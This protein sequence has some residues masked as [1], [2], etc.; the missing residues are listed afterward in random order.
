MDS[1]TSLHFSYDNP[2]MNIKRLLFFTCILG[3]LVLLLLNYS[4]IQYS[5][6]M[7]AGQ[8]NIVWNSKPIDEVLQDVSVP[9]SVKQKL[10]LVLSIKKFATD[11]LGMK[12]SENYST[13]FDQQGK[14]VLWVV[15][16]SE[17]F[18]LKE[19]EWDFPF[20]GKV[21]Y[22][23][24][25]DRQLAENEK[26]K[27][28]KEG[29][30]VELGTTS[31]WSTLGWLK[32]PIMSEML[33]RSEGALA[34]LIIHE[35]THENIFITDK[36]TYNENL[37][38]FVGEQGAVFFLESKYGKE[39]MPV[40]QYKAKLGDTELFQQHILTGAQSLKKLYSS[41]NKNM[42]LEEKDSLKKLLITKILNAADSL[43]YSEYHQKFQR[44][45][46]EINNVFFLDYITYDSQKEE[47]KHILK[48]QY[49]GQFKKY[50]QYLL[51]LSEKQ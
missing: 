36:V 2:R 39:S 5:L 16:A 27:L 6:R 50:F 47:H 1:Q 38:S 48:N 25:F 35:L 40:K 24:F 8:L 9:D 41:F 12:P 10:N 31:G 28:I 21:P 7:A 14:P 15:S 33:K 43:P 18:Q 22:K 26:Q 45:T 13:F 3:C 4:L 20:L 42:S 49:Q 29:Y 32:D 11:S 44:N 17:K 23:G 19:F 46:D 51:T 34:N 37:A 30:D